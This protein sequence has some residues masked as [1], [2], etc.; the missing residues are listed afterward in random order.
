MENSKLSMSEG[1]A[2]FWTTVFAGVT[3]ISL[4]AAGLYSLVQYFDAKDRER[5][6]RDKDRAALQ[7]QIRATSLAAKQAFNNKHLELCAEAAIAAGTVATTKNEA[8]KRM[9]QDDFWRLYWGP[10]GIVEDSEVAAAMVAFGK[11]LEGDCGQRPPR[12]RALDLAHAC[13]VEVS[14]DFQI[15]L[16]ALPDRPLTQAAKN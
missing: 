10:L 6:S 7:L 9:A 3:A 5:E 12:L 4:I 15:D 2:R 16:P 11:C 8:K 14:R 1:A 13:R